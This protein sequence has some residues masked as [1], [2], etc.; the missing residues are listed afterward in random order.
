MRELPIF[1]LFFFYDDADWVGI[2]E[3]LKKNP[4]PFRVVTTSYSLNEH[5]KKNGIE[6]KTMLEIFPE[7]AEQTYEVY[8]ESK[9]VEKRYR[10]CLEHV[11]FSGFRVFEGLECTLIW[12]IILQ[13]KIRK[14][15]SEG[16]STVL[17]LEQFSFT[18][19]ALVKLALEMGYSGQMR[20]CQLKN[21]NVSFVKPDDNL[22]S[23]QTRQRYFY[24]RSAYSSKISRRLHS[25]KATNS[26][27]ATGQEPNQQEAN[28]ESS[29]I[30]MQQSISGKV[31]STAIRYI[32]AM[33]VSKIFSAFHL[34]PAKYVARRIERKMIRTG[35]LTAESAFFFTTN[36][37]DLYLK[38]LYPVL[39]E[40]RARNTK[41]NVFT[42]DLVTADILSVKGV[43]F[44]DLFY[45]VIILLEGIKKSQQGSKLEADVIDA[46]IKHDLPL[47]YLEQLST[48]LSWRIHRV[49]AIMTICDYIVKKTGL[50]SAIIANDPTTFGHSAATVCEKYE[51]PTFFVP[52]T[53]I[54]SNPL[55]ADWI[56]S[57][58]ICIYG[59]QGVEVL[60]GLGYDR[61]RIILT[62]NPKYDQNKKFDQQQSKT[63]LAKEYCIDSSRKL[64]LVGM[65]RWHQN[66]ELWM[67]K[68]IKFCNRNNIEVVIKIHP[69]YKT[70]LSFKESEEKIQKISQECQGLRHLITYDID[71]YTVM[72][73]ADLVI[74]DYSNVGAEAALFEKP[75][76][77]VNFNKESLI[78]EQRYHEIGGAMYFEDYDRMERTILEIFHDG[79]HLDELK[80]GRKKLADM[81]NYYNDGNA[82]KRIV[83]LVLEYR[84]S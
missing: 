80:A 54:N 49:A 45:E 62:G 40:L 8:K 10:Q 28:A 2:T 37:G 72:S 4:E 76:L 38:S 24:L 63:I 32:F 12:Q 58:K 26:N 9:R 51:I 7:E 83:D 52:S 42:S 69:M 44:V 30:N 33:T 22:A 11:T 25:Q 34:D 15:L 35:S 43:P 79:K 23:L 17:I 70:M 18:Y 74:T 29:L 82:A 67:S 41:F 77:T 61:N 14:I 59:L 20:I 60:T 47:V 56:K 50:K 3:R 57:S 53:I 81:Y 16:K 46:A 84:S 21:G 19:F 55:H 68:L 48:D 75:I 1:D 66:D 64:I 36:K 6:S 13:E 71:L 73:A 31:A 39:D 5:L 27:T 78:N 65:A